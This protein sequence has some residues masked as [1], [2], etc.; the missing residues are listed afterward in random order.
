MVLSLLVPY[1]GRVFAAQ[2]SHN[3]DEPWKSHADSGEILLT[4]W[5]I[6]LIPMDM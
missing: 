2:L 1:A 4:N 5:G 3:D 6:Y